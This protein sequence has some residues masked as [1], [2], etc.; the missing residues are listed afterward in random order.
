MKYLVMRLLFGE[1]IARRKQVVI[2]RRTRRLCRTRYAQATRTN[3]SLFQ[4]K[5]TKGLFVLY[6]GRVYAGGRVSVSVRHVLLHPL[7]PT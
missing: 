7:P 4:A 2:R 6:K 5:Q 3:G 1:C